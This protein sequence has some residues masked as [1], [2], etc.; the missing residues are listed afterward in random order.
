MGWNLSNSSFLAGKGVTHPTQMTVMRLKF[1]R[2]FGGLSDSRCFLSC[3]QDDGIMVIH[4][5]GFCR[6]GQWNHGGWMN[7][8]I[9]PGA[10]LPTMSLAL[11]ILVVAVV[12]VAVVL[13]GHGNT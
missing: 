4:S 6:S 2:F 9:F 13:F 12:A 1:P 11:C 7:T 8:Y 5:I 10:E 3:Q